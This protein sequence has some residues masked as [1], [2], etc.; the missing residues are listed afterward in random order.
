MDW[1]WLSAPSPLEVLPDV[2]ILAWLG[3]SLAC[4]LGSFPFLGG[5]LVGSVVK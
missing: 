5:A 4:D 1:S 2:S 3:H